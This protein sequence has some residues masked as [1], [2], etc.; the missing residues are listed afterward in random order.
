VRTHRRDRS[1]GLPLNWVVSACI[2]M[3]VMGCNK[4]YI[5]TLEENRI[6]ARGV[7][8]MGMIREGYCATTSSATASRSTCLLYTNLKS[9]WDAMRRAAL[10]KW[11]RR[12]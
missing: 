1:E 11:G 12:R 7:E 5:E 2:G 3:D 8:R 6:I 10:R 4:L 9:E